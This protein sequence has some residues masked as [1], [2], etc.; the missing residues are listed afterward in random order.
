MSQPNDEVELS[1]LFVE[2]GAIKI[3]E[4]QYFKIIMVKITSV[5]LIVVVFIKSHKLASDLSLSSASSVSLILANKL[6]G[7]G[8]CGRRGRSWLEVM[9]GMKDELILDS[10]GEGRSSDGSCK[11]PPL[12]GGI[13]NIRLGERQEELV[14]IT[15]FSR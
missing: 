10:R 1:F 2:S 8:V 5:T 14:P 15:C 13:S 6:F 12:K 4:G 3:E 11:D 9:P 7:G